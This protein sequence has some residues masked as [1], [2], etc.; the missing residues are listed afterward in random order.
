MRSLTLWIL[1]MLTSLAPVAMAQPSESDKATARALLD[2]GDAHMN[3]QRFEEAAKAYQAADD[4][5]KVPT[6]GFPLGQAQ[7]A[8]GKLLEASSTLLRVIRFPVE[9]GEPSAFT[10][11]RADADKLAGELKPRIPKLSFKLEG[12]ADGIAPNVL[13]DGSEIKAAALT[14]PRQVNPGAHKISASAEGYKAISL[15]VDVAE[16]ATQ[17]LVLTFEV[18]PNFVAAV[19]PVPATEP[20][21]KADPK[22]DV[23]TPTDRGISILTIVGFSIGGAGLIAG[24]ITGGLSL[25]KGSTLQDECAA[26]AT[27]GDA[28][29]PDRQ[30]DVDSALL[31]SHISTISFAVG[32]AGFVLGFVS[33]VFDLGADG[34]TTSSSLRPL[35]G[36]GY[37]GVSG[38]F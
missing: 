18:D 17:D 36:P 6:T 10:T 11:A 7:A 33:L 16:G 19:V 13:V 32:G 24:A 27:P 20:T 35:L 2:D 14:F 8:S 28:C 30:G 15:H 9:G 31:V 34:A 26:D 4:L 37:V 3:A 21:P 12:L 25:A 1:L 22:P 29:D 38:R 23:V 5:M